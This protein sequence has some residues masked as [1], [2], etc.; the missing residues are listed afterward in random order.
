[1]KKHASKTCPGKARYLSGKRILPRPISQ[2]TGIVELID[3]LDAKLMMSLRE[4]RGGG[5]EGGDW[6]DYVK[7]IGGRLYRPDLTVEAEERPAAP[8]ARSVGPA[9]TPPA[10]RAAPDPGP[11]SPPTLSNPAFHIEPPKR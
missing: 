4:C 11:A 1:M 3:N 9:R 7:A 2:K 10:S 8:P 6:T 5:G